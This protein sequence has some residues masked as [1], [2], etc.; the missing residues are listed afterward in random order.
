MAVVV[1]VVLP[2]ALLAGVAALTRL[3]PASQYCGEY[4]GC[5][6]Y[7]VLAWEVGR[8]AAIVLAWPLLHLLRVRPA[9]PVAVLAGLFLTVVWQVAQ[10]M[11]FSLFLESLVLIVASG[12]IA[13]PAAAWFTMPH[14]T[15][16]TLVIAVVVAFAIYACASAYIFLFAG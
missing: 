13:Y 6:G 5:F 9:L 3:Y 4:T 14:I 10:A 16:R 12:V 2:V 11:P 15:R 1:G 7:L 8:W